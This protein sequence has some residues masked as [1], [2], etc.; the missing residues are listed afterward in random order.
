MF[1]LLAG[2][3]NAKAPEELQSGWLA[4]MVLP[5]AG[6]AELKE[7]CFLPWWAVLLT[8]HPLCSPSRI[9]LGM[10]HLGAHRALGSSCGVEELGNGKRF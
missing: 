2:S 6:L 1:V 4:S 7:A 10:L 8:S 9:N 3:Q 5:E